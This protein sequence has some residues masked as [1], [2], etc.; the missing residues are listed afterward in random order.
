MW[1]ESS[2]EKFMPIYRIKLRDKQFYHDYTS[3]FSAGAL[4]AIYFLC[5]TK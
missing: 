5:C 3:I 4:C 2:S 1:T